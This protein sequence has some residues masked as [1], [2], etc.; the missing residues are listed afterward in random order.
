MFIDW[1]VFEKKL[2]VTSRPWNVCQ[3]AFM[4]SIL[5]MSLRVPAFLALSPARFSGIFCSF[6]GMVL[7]VF[8]LVSACFV[9][10][11][12]LVISIHVKG[13]TL[14]GHRPSPNEARWPTSCKRTGLLFLFCI[15]FT[16]LLFTVESLHN[17]LVL[18]ACSR[19]C[20]SWPSAWFACVAE[21][22]F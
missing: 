5:I 18:W 10:I 13:E 3:D 14:P 21:P 15:T 1:S 17:P 6:L 16:C 22:D 9:S 4:L 11:C 19:V 12:Y 20:P 8:L 2:R 7:Q